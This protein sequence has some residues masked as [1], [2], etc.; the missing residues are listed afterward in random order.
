MAY[1][2]TDEG[3]LTPK[4]GGGYDCE[5]FIKDHLGN[6]RVT[7]WDSAGVAVVQQ[8]NHYYPFGMAMQGDKV[9]YQNPNKE[10]VNKY[11]YNG[12]EMQDDHGLDWLDYGA[13]FYDAALGRFHTI[14]RFAEK[15][16]SYSP[17]GY[18]AN[19][20]IKYIDVNGD[21]LW[22]NTPDGNLLYQNGSM[23]TKDK[24][25]NISLYK[26]KYAKLDKKGNVK[27]YKGALGGHV[28]KLDKIAKSKFGS[29]MISTLEGSEYNYTIKTI[30]GSSRFAADIG[31]GKTGVLNN[32]AYAFQVMDQ[33]SLV[34]SHVGFN[35][36]GSGGDILLN[37]NDDYMTLAHEL[38]HAYD[39]SSGTLDSREVMINGGLEEIREIRAVYYQNRISQDLG[40]SLRKR[41]RQDGPKLL[42]SN[43]NPIFYPTPF[44]QKLSPLK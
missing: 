32:N 27:G 5:Y 37:A 28:N 3:R 33:G 21:S 36:I 26:G 23:Y 40:K 17:Y 8:E 24:K 14:D 30:K 20:P 15:Y 19:D 4:D 39:A 44:L 42:D 25:G 16:F 22:I 6:N 2:L 29:K 38:G 13:R 1:V 31:N 34:Y 9:A 11:L 10:N 12:K 43:K 35:Q 18:A 7:V 41:Y